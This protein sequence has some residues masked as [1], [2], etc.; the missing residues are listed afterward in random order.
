[1]LMHGHTSPAFSR[2]EHVGYTAGEHEIDGD[3]RFRL[4]GPGSCLT[5]DWRSAD[6]RAA[7]FFWVQ[8]SPAKPSPAT[9]PNSAI[10]AFFGSSRSLPRTS[11]PQTFLRDPRSGVANPLRREA[12]GVHHITSMPIRLAFSPPPPDKV[13]S[14]DIN[15]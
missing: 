10:H 1:M 6:A 8:I 12:R 4:D 3:A 15:S 13:L 2:N 14:R 7:R 11:E 9:N 5:S